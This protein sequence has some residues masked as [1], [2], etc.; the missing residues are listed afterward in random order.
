M[1]PRTWKATVTRRATWNTTS[2]IRPYCC[3]SHFHVRT[4]LSFSQLGEK[5]GNIGLT[6]LHNVV[7]NLS[8]SH[9]PKLFSYFF[10]R[11][12]YPSHVWQP[13]HNTI[14]HNLFYFVL[15]LVHRRL[16]SMKSFESQKKN[17]EE[18]WQI[19]Q[20]IL[21]LSN[22]RMEYTTFSCFDNFVRGNC[23]G[24][25]DHTPM[26]YALQHLEE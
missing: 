9:S 6:L 15:F 26:H 7:A 20:L 2:R 3:A 21:N 11:F 5:S 10:K 4:L 8:T 24:I 17:Y 23:A 22:F 14:F 16:T 13:N 18:Y 19:R 1:S 25:P 12:V